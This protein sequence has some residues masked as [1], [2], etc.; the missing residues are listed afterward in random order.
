MT[1]IKNPPGV[2]RGAGGKETAERND[3]GITTVQ[4]ARERDKID[5][6]NLISTIARN[7][8][9]WRRRGEHFSACRAIRNHFRLA[10]AAIDLKKMS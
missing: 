9:F 5:A 4:L 6:L 8:S 7:F 3:I 1:P 2:V 10:V